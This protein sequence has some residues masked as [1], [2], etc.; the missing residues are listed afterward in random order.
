[1]SQTHCVFFLQVNK[2]KRLKYG[3]DEFFK[4]ERLLFS[5]VDH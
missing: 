3:S 5:Q 4:Y 2:L 1:M